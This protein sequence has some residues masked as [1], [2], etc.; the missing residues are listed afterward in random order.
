MQADEQAVMALRT[1]NR[2]TY[3]PP[4]YSSLIEKR[5]TKSYNFNNASYAGGSTAQCIINSGKDALWGPNCYLRVALTKSKVETEFS[6]NTILAIFKRIRLTHRSGEVLEYI[7]DVGLLAHIRRLYELSLDERGKL[8]SLITVKAGANT[9]NQVLVVPLWLLLGV[10]N[11][12]TNYIP[13]GFLAGSKLEIDLADNK[14]AV[15]AAGTYEVSMTINLESSQIW[16]GA[17]KQLL[18]Q[19]AS[20]D[21]SG[22]QFNYST[23]F[24]SN[25]AAGTNVNFDVQHAASITEK[26]IHAYRTTANFT[27][28]GKDSFELNPVSRAQVR[29]ASDYY[30][31]QPLD[32]SVSQSEA[33]QHALV[34]FDGAPK[35]YLGSNSNGGVSVSLADWSSATDTSL[36][37]VYAQTLEM[38]SVGIAFTGDKTNNSRQLRIEVEKPAAGTRIDVFLQYIRIANVMGDNLVVDR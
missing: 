37:P 32:L 9:L 29:L 2:L 35:Q 28:E 1:V 3:A 19:E 38:S 26:V 7:P 13:P 34:A 25:N 11:V 31:Q 27:D 16:D 33:Y 36:G 5:T 18:D 17:M 6:G 8:D 21:T 12:R 23:W 24:A 10:F 4:H 14:E 15:K 30:P 22:L 20:V